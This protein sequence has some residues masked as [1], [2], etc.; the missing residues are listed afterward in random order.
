VYID[1][2]GYGW[3]L[4]W[5][6]VFFVAAIIDTVTDGAISEAIEDAIPDNVEVDVEIGTSIPI[7]PEDGQ[8][9]ILPKEESDASVYDDIENSSARNEYRAEYYGDFYNNYGYYDD[10]L[11]V[12]YSDY[13]N[14]IR[15]YL[16]FGDPDYRD[17]FSPWRERARNWWRRSQ[18]GWEIPPF[19]SEDFPIAPAWRT[20]SELNPLKGTT[21]FYL[22]KGI[23]FGPIYGPYTF[24]NP[25]LE[26]RR[27][28]WYYPAIIL[29][30]NGR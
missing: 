5:A 2:T 12:S 14:T 7:G 11:T 6:I 18:E 23:K 9:T 1:P 19:W 17:T 24:W 30:S 28:I 3:G 13:S 16:Q 25:L 27:D 20:K 22:Q 10:S 29:H 8:P 26:T 15:P 4:F 21:T